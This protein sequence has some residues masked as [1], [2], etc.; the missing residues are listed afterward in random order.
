MPTTTTSPRC[1][2]TVARVL[3]GA[4]S[5]AWLHVDLRHRLSAW[6]LVHEGRETLTRLLESPLLAGNIPVRSDGDGLSADT[7]AL[8]LPDEIPPELLALGDKDLL[9]EARLDDL[10]WIDDV[11]RLRGVAFTRYV[12]SDRAHEVSLSL[13]R[14]AGGEPR[15]G[16]DPPR[17]GRGRQRVRR[18]AL[19]GPP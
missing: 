6:A 19:R 2:E 8:G 18:P 7:A 10:G 4:P 5:G 9:V 16:A 3:D 15:A 1:V 12:D 17:A 14:R 11:L 13:R